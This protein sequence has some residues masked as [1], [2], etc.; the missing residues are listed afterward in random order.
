MI[1]TGLTAPVLLAACS[2]DSR[3]EDDPYVRLI[4]EQPISGWRPSAEYTARLEN[5]VA[6]TVDHAPTSSVTQ[7]YTFSTSALAQ[8]ALAA[9]RAQTASWQP[10][11]G[12]TFTCRS[13]K[14]ETGVLVYLSATAINSLPTNGPEGPRLQLEF[15]CPN[16]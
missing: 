8:Q 6:M 3:V 10:C 7:V 2:H 12:S 14:A 11:P 16:P 9:V 13:T 15:R 5:V 4:R 1:V